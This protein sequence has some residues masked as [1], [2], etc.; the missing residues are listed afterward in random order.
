VKG[1][2]VK[3]QSWRI[4]GV[5]SLLIA[6]TG[7][8]HAAEVSAA[9]VPPVLQIG[10]TNITNDSVVENADG[11]FTLVGTESGGFPERGWQLDWDLTVDYDPFINGSLTLTN[12]GTSA[13]NFVLNLELPVPAIAGPTLFGGSITASVF[14]DSQNGIATLTRSTATGASP[15]IYQSFIDNSPVLNL[16]GVVPLECSGSGPN[17]SASL[18]DQDGLPGP[19]IPGSAVSQKIRSVLMFN[20]SA[21]DRV[22]FNTNFTVIPAP[23][24]LPASVWTLL[25]ALGAVGYLVH[26]RKTTAHEAFFPAEAHSRA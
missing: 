20:L 5:V 11:S 2:I 1:R 18:S 26:K 10:S 16:F 21:G 23:V 24:P 25:A 6:A 9:F 19:V 8:T 22:T 15:G 3:L 13:R 17:C 4:A 12:F 7:V 14:D